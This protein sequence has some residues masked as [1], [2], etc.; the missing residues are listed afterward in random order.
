MTRRPSAAARARAGR[1]RR[2]RRRVRPGLAEQAGAPDLA[3]RRGRRHRRV[4][5]PARAGAVAEPRPAVH[6]RQPRRRGRHGRR[7]HRR[8][9]AA[10]RLHVPRRRRAPHDR[11][12]R[13]QQAAVRP[14]ARPRAGDAGGDRC[15]SVVVVHPKVP[16]N[17]IAELIA[18]AKA[19][20]DKLNAA[21]AGN[22][23]SHH[24]TLELFKVR[25]GT[26]INHIPYKGAGPAMQDLIAG[27]VDLM[28]DGMG[29]VVAADQGR[30]AASARGDDADARA[31]DSRTSRRCRKRACGHRRDDVVRASGRR[32]ARRRRSST[33]CSRRSRR[34][35]RRRSSRKSGRSKAA[36]ARRQP[37]GR[38]R[39][40]REDRDR[41]LGRG[42][43]GVGGADR[44]IRQEAEIGDREIE[45]RAGCRD[46]PIR[47]PISYLRSQPFVHS[48]TM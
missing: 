16:I 21:S 17:S 9:G 30:A 12:Q 6:R 13:L 4:R 18:Y 41:A 2:S 19:N 47:S 24:L 43:E 22:G 14:R 38:V 42:R 5:A 8:E 45:I 35:C 46:A 44:L 34:R 20:P 27:Q 36:T 31:R 29:T 32:P 37:A 33:G 26:Q 25:T 3:V 1:A 15:P 48:R 23:T 28:F 40:V 10:R 39:R 11:G 7:R